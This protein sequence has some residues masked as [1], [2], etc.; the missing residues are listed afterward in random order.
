MSSDISQEN[1]EA[2][3]LCRDY[4][5]TEFITQA[6]KC[7]R[8]VRSDQ[9]DAATK[10]KLNKR[11]KP[12]LTIN[13]ILSVFA[14][15]AGEQISR[16]GDVSF[17]PGTG[18]DPQTAAALDKLWIH[19]AQTQKLNWK[20]GLAFWDGVIRSR[21]FVDLR[22]TFDEG[23]RGEPVLSYLNSKDVLLYPF[24]TGYDPDDWQGVIVTRMM[25]PTTIH[26]LYNAPLDDIIG[27]TGGDS[28]VP[29]Y[30]D[31]QRDSFGKPI[32][33]VF[34]L[35]S[36]QREKYR[37]LR[38]IERQ[39][40][41]YVSAECFVDR[42]TGE[43]RM[44]P[45]SWDRERIRNTIAQHDYAVVRK[46]M[47]K[48]RWAVSV[49][50]LS[51]HNSISPYRHLTP[52]PYFPFLI[53][54]KPTGIVEHLIG[55]QDLLNKSLSQ[56]LHIVAGIANSGWK[57]K[58][59]SI[60][61]MTATQLREQGGEDGLVLEMNTSL[62]DVER[63]SPNQIPQGLDRLSFKASEAMQQISL[64]S[65]SM[66]GLDRA[67]VSGTAIRTKA[68]RGSLALTPI[69]TTLAETRQLIARN[70]LDLTQQFVTE[71]RVYKITLPTRKAPTEEVTVNQEQ[72]DGSFLNDLTLGEYGI[73]ITDVKQRDDFD[74]EQFGYMVD[75]IRNGAPIPWS[76]AADSLTILENKDTVVEA[77]KQREGLNPPGEQEKRRAELENAQLE[78]AVADKQASAA[79]KN[80]QA[81]RA[82]AEAAKSG[83]PD[84]T[85]V[86]KLQTEK[87][88][89]DMDVAA[90]QQKNQL[91]MQT[92]YAKLDAMTQ[93]YELGMRKMQQELQI[94]RERMNMELEHMREMHAIEREKA[95]QE[96]ELRRVAGALDVTQKKMAG[97]QK[98]EAD[99][100]A[101]EQKAE[102]A[103]A[104]EKKSTDNSQ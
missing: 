9:W 48:I 59:G 86:V 53:G 50:G 46:R 1:K 104:A 70:W 64:V 16:R 75:M 35:P 32:S 20:E 69:Y 18:G 103:R 67:D 74:M 77:L 96:L 37:R 33:G 2:Y 79:V 66:Q 84:M 61:N 4:G 12:F 25:S 95:R 49:G 42:A 65:E 85:E 43:V 34:D 76:V 72:P 14:V 82:T 15:L 21:G 10:A 58:K 93:Q 7:D 11:R 101:A 36:E 83:E 28:I 22:A 44:I 55:T 81:Q 6:E 78:A 39:E 26:E 27:M 31:W 99:R 8:Y 63:L 94:S 87:Q 3:E 88:K 100:V 17:R 47:R 29:D 102:L 89:A 13:K 97:E 57:M 54:G 19:F 62:A 38:V 90:A 60:A 73:V 56:E 41:E 30:A 71:E 24:D 92:L 98:L 91:T 23:M 68:D 80:A 45:N 52:I 5:H 51:L 40:F